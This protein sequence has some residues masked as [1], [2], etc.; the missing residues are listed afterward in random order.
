MK[1]KVIELELQK[2]RDM[3]NIEKQDVVHSKIAVIGGLFFGGGTGVKTTL[4]SGWNSKS[5]V[6]VHIK[7][8]ACTRKETSKKCFREVRNEGLAGYVR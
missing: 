8:R 4:N 3:Q 7:P 5:R 1:I 2:Y 6:R